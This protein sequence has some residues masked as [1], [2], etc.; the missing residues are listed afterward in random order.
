MTKHETIVQYIKIALGIIV[1][2]V[3]V[4]KLDN[5]HQ[6]LQSIRYILLNL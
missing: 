1:F 5:I 3:L 2:L 6:D 4:V